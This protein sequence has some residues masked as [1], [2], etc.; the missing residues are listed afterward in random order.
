MHQHHCKII[1]LSLFAKQKPVRDYFFLSLQQLVMLL[2]MC[3]K[4]Q[5]LI[6]WQLTQCRI[7]FPHSA[8]Y[9]HVIIYI[10]SNWI[11]ISSLLFTTVSCLLFTVYFLLLFTVLATITSPCY[12]LNIFSVA[13]CHTTFILLIIGP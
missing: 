5:L 1:W 6:F 3:K 13:N 4:L 9:Q 11:K 7:I 10:Y 12:L 2:Q 8:K